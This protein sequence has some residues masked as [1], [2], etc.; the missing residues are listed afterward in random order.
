MSSLSAEGREA[1]VSRFF[2]VEMDILRTP[3]MIGFADAQPKH[4]KCAYFRSDRIF[5]TGK[6]GGQ[7][8]PSKKGKGSSRGSPSSRVTRLALPYGQACNCQF[9]VIFAC[10]CHNARKVAAID[11]SR[12]T[13]QWDKMVF[14]RERRRHRVSAKALGRYLY[15]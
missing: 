11:R 12:H 6:V 10:S 1:E 15:P 9:K 2:E 5:R 14:F 4:D 3:S 8:P 7:G 13:A